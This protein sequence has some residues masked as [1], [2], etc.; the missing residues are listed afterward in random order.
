M[1]AIARSCAYALAFLIF[2]LGAEASPPVIAD[3]GTNGYITGTVT[4]SQTGLP[5]ANAVV[6]LFRVLEADNEPI[7]RPVPLVVPQMTNA[8]GQYTLFTE[9]PGYIYATK[10]GYDSGDRRWSVPPQNGA[11]IELKPLVTATFEESPHR[12]E[13][14]WAF[15]NNSDRPVD[16]VA[17]VYA[18]RN[19]PMCNRAN[20]QTAP[21]DRKSRA[22]IPLAETIVPPGSPRTFYVFRVQGARGDG[23]SAK[24]SYCYFTSVDGPTKTRTPAFDVVTWANTS[25]SDTPCRDILSPPPT[26][27]PDIEKVHDA[28]RDAQRDTE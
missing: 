27:T 15:T 17:W 8:A 16:V 1:P 14:A 18:C 9:L 10:A 21:A 6:T 4:D 22:V 25:K 3:T 11:N 12:Y 5:I 7:L 23:F 20:T 24:L 2:A 28:Q 19:V 26:D 13:L